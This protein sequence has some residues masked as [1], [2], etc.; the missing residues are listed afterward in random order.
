MVERLNRTLD[1]YL[2]TVVDTNQT[3]F[4][5]HIPLFQLAYRS[6]V[7]ESTGKTPASVVFERELCLP[8]D[9][10]FGRPEKSESSN[11]SYSSKLV[12]RLEVIHGEVRQNL[13]FESDRLKTRYDAGTVADSK[14]VI[15]FGYIILLGRKE[16]LSY[17]GY[18]RDHTTL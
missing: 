11:D 2:R 3:D 4:D 1:N 15:K 9:I 13:K 10:L 12:Q 14:L 7:H 6:A 8:M 17:R 18:G 5:Q 16:S